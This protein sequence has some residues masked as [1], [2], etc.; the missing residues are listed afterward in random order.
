MERLRI[1]AIGAGYWGPNLIRNFV[2]LPTTDLIAVADLKTERLDHL[3]RLYP[4][5]QTTQNYT[6]LFQMNL[7][8]VVIATP[9]ATHYQVAKECL[10]HGLHILVE[11]PL[12]LTSAD[13]Q[14]LI[15]LAQER[16]LKL[17]VGHTFEYNSAV[18][19]LKHLIDSGQIGD[20]Y[21]IDAVRTNLGLYQSSANV[22]WDL[23]PHDISIILYLLG[24]TPTT[25]NANGAN[26]IW[27]K[28]CD[29]AY[30][31]LGFANGVQAHIRNSWLDPQKVRR[32]TVVGSKKMVVYDDVETLE[33]IKIY[34]KGVDAPPYTDTFGEFQL[35]YRYGDIVTPHISTKEPLRAEC[36]E[37][38]H[39]I[40]TDKRPQTDGENGLRVV[41]ILEAAKKSLEN[42]GN[43][44]LIDLAD[45][46][47][48]Q[49]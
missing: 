25:V 24:E 27:Q 33:K 38:A 3:K 31:C 14:A 47:V 39:C 28:T 20:I 44:T 12:T 40:L 45:Y 16:N 37:F 21:Y 19:T 8:A 10:E 34:D 46:P 11:K 32:L 29:V 49:A 42:H 6:D 15:T 43:Q 17:M 36:E 7:D 30:I 9:P 5:I 23:A 48:N 22:M 13:A 2:E 26:Y 35:S 18:Q 4:S 1:G 41:K